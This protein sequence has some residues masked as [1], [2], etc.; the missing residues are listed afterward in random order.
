MWKVLISWE[1]ITYRMLPSD[2]L[3]YRKSRIF[4]A[5]S[6]RAPRANARAELARVIGLLDRGDTPPTAGI[7]NHDTPHSLTPNYI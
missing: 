3:F 6:A 1:L 7:P 4:I 2:F 5:R